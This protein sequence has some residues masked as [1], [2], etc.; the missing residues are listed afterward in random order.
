MAGGQGEHLPRRLHP[1]P[2]RGGGDHLD[3]LRLHDQGL[4]HLV[5]VEGLG[6]LDQDR[7][8]GLEPG[9]VLEDAPVGVAVPGDGD[10]AQLARQR[11]A[12][13]VPG[14]LD[15]EHLVHVHPFGQRELRPI[16]GG[17]V[18]G[19]PDPGVRGRVGHRGGPLLRL[20]DAGVR[21]DLAPLLL[22]AG[23]DAALLPLR[24]DVR[25][26]QLPHQEQHQQHPGGQQQLAEHPGRGG[27]PCAAVGGGHSATVAS[28]VREPTKAGSVISRPVTIFSPRPT[29]STHSR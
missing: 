1:G 16:E 18:H 28:T 9:D 7:V 20:G 8:P 10:V 11:G 22:E 3:V 19:R 26:P 2:A 21:F 14:P 5:D 6:R 25:P 12:R 17:H 24:P 13:I 23:E 27:A 29:C 4:G 15:V